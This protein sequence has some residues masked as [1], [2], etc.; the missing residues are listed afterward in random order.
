MNSLSLAKRC[1]FPLRWVRWLGNSPCLKWNL[2]SWALLMISQ[3][4]DFGPLRAE[5]PGLVRKYEVTS[6]L[7]SLYVSSINGS[8]HYTG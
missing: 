2:T 3:R 1:G 8:T 4:K 7:I 6:T 5:L